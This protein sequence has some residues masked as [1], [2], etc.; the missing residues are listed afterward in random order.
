MDN[1]KLGEGFTFTAFNCLWYNELFLDELP[2]GTGCILL[3]QDNN[4]DCGEKNVTE[5]YRMH[6]IETIT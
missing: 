5:R 1:C 2:R 4:K 6:P 3:R